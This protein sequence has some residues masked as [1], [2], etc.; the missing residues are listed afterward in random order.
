[1]ATPTSCPYHPN[2]L[3]FDDA[4]DD[5]VHDGAS[6]DLVHTNDFGGEPDPL[7]I[8]QADQAVLSN[9]SGVDI[10]II[11][12]AQKDDAQYGS[13]FFP[14]TWI[15]SGT[16]AWEPNL[17]RYDTGI[18]TLEVGYWQLTVVFKDVDFGDQTG[19]FRLDNKAPFGTYTWNSGTIGDTGET[20]LVTK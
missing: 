9:T 2:S 6:D 16:L 15:V 18:I 19:F 11:A 12:P 4:S 14:C 1:M 7:V 3:V 17:W 10:E 8:L 5:L 20:L 13:A